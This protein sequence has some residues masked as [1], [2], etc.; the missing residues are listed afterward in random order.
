M[1][2]WSLAAAI[3]CVVFALAGSATINARSDAIGDAASAAF[4]L[5]RLEEV[6]VAAVEADSIATTSFLVGGL[7][8]SVRRARFEDRLDV[9]TRTLTAVATASGNTDQSAAEAD[10]L[11]KANAA[12]NR[13]AGL[14]EQARSNNRQALPVGAAYQRE[15]STLMRDVVVAEL[16]IAD[17][18]VRDDVNRAVRSSRTA[19]S[20]LHLSTLLALGVLVGASVWMARRTSRFINLGLAGASL[21]V[22]VTWVLSG[23]AMAGAQSAVDDTASGPLSTLDQL[24]QGR[25]AAFDA[26][27]LEALT[28]I[29]RGSGGAYQTQWVGEADLASRQF[30]AACIADSS[31]CSP[32]SD[33][34]SYRA[35]HNNVRELDDAGTWDDAVAMALST[36]AGGGGASFETFAASSETASESAAEAVNRGFDDAAGSISSRQWLVLL[37]GLV[38]A[39]AAIGGISQRVREYR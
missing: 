23:P 7:E 8:D 24:G 17:A 31:K 10:A 18:I 13:F 38:A 36:E 3:A 22:L 16:N 28:L 5:E 6:R 15:A 2:L 39:G 21:V 32:L 25:A 27:S 1:R 30:D 19:A 33:F 37:G 20:P 34:E 9:A 14:I 29:S 11:A 35:V 12:L 26:R 4:R